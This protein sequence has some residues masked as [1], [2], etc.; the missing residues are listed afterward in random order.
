[1]WVSNY[2]MLLCDHPAVF[3]EQCSPNVLC[4]LLKDWEALKCSDGWTAWCNLHPL[5]SC[6]LAPVLTLARKAFSEFRVALEIW[7]KKFARS[8]AIQIWNLQI[9]CRL[10]VSWW[11]K[12]ICEKNCEKVLNKERAPN[13]RQSHHCLST[14]SAV[15]SGFSFSFYFVCKPKL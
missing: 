11:L 5:R 1:M 15:A 12:K 14:W 10:Q 6:T 2:A 4:V 13:E 7:I 9:F 8:L 3:S